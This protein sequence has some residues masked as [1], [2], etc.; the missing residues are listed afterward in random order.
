[1]SRARPDHPGVQGVVNAIRSGDTGSRSSGLRTTADLGDC[2]AHMHTLL[3]QQLLAAANAASRGEPVP[4]IRVMLTDGRVGWVNVERAAFD[5]WGATLGLGS[6]LRR[7]AAHYEQIDHFQRQKL[8]YNA[9]IN[10]DRLIREQQ[11]E[12]ERAR[13]ELVEQLRPFIRVIR[14]DT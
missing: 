7:L 13:V 10:F 3:A 5:L 14:T 12:I 8:S 4:D 6:M 1:M 11:D 2:P 9:M